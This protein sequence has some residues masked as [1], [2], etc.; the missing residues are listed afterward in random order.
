MKLPVSCVLY[1][2]AQIDRFTEIKG[3]LFVKLGSIGYY[4]HERLLKRFGTCNKQEEVGEAQPCDD[5]V[6][7]PGDILGLHW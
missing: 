1:P 6:G 2:R 5:D 3:K 7:E 4:Q